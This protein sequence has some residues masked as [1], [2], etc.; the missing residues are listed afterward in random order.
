MARTPPR[1]LSS[2]PPSRRANSDTNSVAAQ[3]VGWS[4]YGVLVVVGLGFGAWTGLQRKTVEVTKSSEP[5]EAKPNEGTGTT[6]V[7]PPGPGTQQQPPPVVPPVVV[8]PPPVVTPPKTPVSTPVTPPKPP[9]TT[10]V[11]PKEMPPAIVPKEPPVTAVALTFEKD[12]KPIFRAKC[13]SCHGDPPTDKKPKGGLDLRTLSAIKAGGDSGAGAI[14]NNL[15]ASPIWDQIDKG[16]MPPPNKDKLTARET[17][18]IKD[19]IM[20]GAK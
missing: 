13:N 10:T 18:M 6:S 9:T 16:D 17:Q 11:K 2:G 8:N 20:S 5:T 19:W 3:W 1:P 14:P 7:T 15:K 12:I 4:I